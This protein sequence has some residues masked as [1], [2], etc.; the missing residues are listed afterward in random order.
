MTEH[1][2]MTD[3]TFTGFEVREELNRAFDAEGLSPDYTLMGF[4]GFYT[5][6]LGRRVYI[7]R[8]PTHLRGIIP[9]PWPLYAAKLP[10][11]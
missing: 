8:R 7:T 10:P 11:T 3:T 6:N 9:P 4:D 5:Q 1:K 2:M